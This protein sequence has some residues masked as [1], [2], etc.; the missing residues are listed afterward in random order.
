VTCTPESPAFL[1]LLPP[2]GPTT[3][4]TCSG[5]DQSGNIGT[6]SFSVTVEDTTAPEFTNVPS[7]PVP[8]AIDSDGLGRLDFESQVTVD[9]VDGV[10]PDPIVACKA[11]GGQASGE[12]LP[13]GLATV[14]CTATDASG[15]SATASYEVQVT[16]GDP[17]GIFVDKKNVK[18]GSSVP[19]RF[20]FAG[21]GGELVDSSGADPIVS[22]RDCATG[23]K[24]VLSPG[25][26]PGNSD[27]RYDASQRLW[28][29]NWQTVLM[30]GTP[31]PGDAYCLQVTSL[32]TG[33]T[34]P[35]TGFTRV[36]VR[37]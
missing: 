34:I 19:L 33:Q 20:G 15:N 14:S 12:G 32:T 23:Q 7:S 16:Y 11:G 26:F 35:E 3:T 13:L 22:S 17:V 28:K 21:A 36:R 27:L 25:E 4:I 24:V 37:D 18:A 29:F 2:E 8:V 6:L 30:D 5:E 1:P 10:D 9:D 31:I